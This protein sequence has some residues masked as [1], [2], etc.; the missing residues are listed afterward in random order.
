MHSSLGFRCPAETDNSLIASFYD[1]PIASLREAVWPLI[2]A[3]VPGYQCHTH[4]KCL[5]D[6]NMRGCAQMRQ[7]YAKAGGNISATKESDLLYRGGSDCG[8]WRAS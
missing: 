6:P 8:C 1:L 3:R 7:D 5:G 4:L 2:Q